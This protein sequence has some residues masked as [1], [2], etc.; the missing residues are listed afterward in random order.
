ME[1]DS[2]KANPVWEAAMLG[3]VAACKLAKKRGHEMDEP[4]ECGNSALHH[5]VIHRH[6][7]VV[8]YLLT[9]ARV[10]PNRINK[11][12]NSALHLAAA[13][14]DEISTQYLLAADADTAGQ[15]MQGDTPLH[16][17]ALKGFSA[18]LGAISDWAAAQATMST[19]E[20]HQFITESAAELCTTEA[21]TMQLCQSLT[22][23]RGLTEVESCSH[24]LVVHALVAKGAPLHIVNNEGKSAFIAAM[25]PTA[26]KLLLANS[27]N[28]AM[29]E[30]RR[31]PL[32]T[33]GVRKCGSCQIS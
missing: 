8:H 24:D 22:E 2:S 20:W 1:E 25:P 32:N 13:A 14:G 21:K 15:N 7:A 6:P 17:A 27:P 11:L 23:W 4:D 3:D 30:P 16:M 10:D 12:G 5:A 26:I 31:V 29:S 18:L 9:T 19:P 33:R 28:A